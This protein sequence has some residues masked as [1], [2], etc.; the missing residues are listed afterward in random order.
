MIS[1]YKPLSPYE[2]NWEVCDP[3][4]EQ[5]V[6]G[7]KGK[8]KKKKVTKGRCN[9]RNA[10]GFLGSCKVPDANRVLGMKPEPW[11]NDMYAVYTNTQGGESKDLSWVDGVTVLPAEKD[12]LISFILLIAFLRYNQDLSFDVD[13]Q[14]GR[15]HAIHGA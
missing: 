3:H 5:E 14:D 11:P 2:V 6:I 9:W 7:K 1:I 10:L 13:L 12:N 4:V 15:I 8:P